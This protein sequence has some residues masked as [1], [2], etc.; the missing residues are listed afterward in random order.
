MV[1][2]MLALPSFVRGVLHVFAMGK[3]LSFDEA[4]ELT[5]ML[6]LPLAGNGEEEK[7]EEGAEEGAEQQ[8]HQSLL[9]LRLASVIE[10]N[11]CGAVLDAVL[12]CGADLTATPSTLAKC[13]EWGSRAARELLHLEGSSVVPLKA[14]ARRAVRRMLVGK[15]GGPVMNV[16]RLP[17]AAHASLV[18]YLMLDVRV[19]CAEAEG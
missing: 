6:R 18:S 15:P 17:F 7:A 8:Q 19:R 16:W 14:L 10:G 3:L 12:A 5:A 13:A 2:G 4:E 1:E 11:A 9:L